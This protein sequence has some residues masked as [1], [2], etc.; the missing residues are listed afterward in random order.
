MRFSE[1]PA[2]PAG[3]AGL[4]KRGNPAQRPAVFLHGAGAN[5]LAWTTILEAFGDRSLFLLDL[6]GHGRS[7]LPE[8]WDLETTAQSVSQLVASVFPNDPILWVGHSWGGKLA[9]VI[10]AQTPEIAAGLVLLDPS[11]SSAVPINIEEFVDVI[12]SEELSSRASESE[13]ISA[14]Q[15]LPQWAPGGTEAAKAIARGVAANENGNWSLRP[16]RQA[17]VDLATAVLHQDATDLLSRAANNSELPTLLVLAEESLPWQEVTNKKL[18]ARA[19]HSV[20]PGNHW[21]H[22]ARHAAVCEEV[23]RWLHLLR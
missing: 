6:P 9:G 17:L 7:P 15:A 23:R 21:V 22:R 14:A 16:G 5:A 3:L 19:S 10:A 13:A 20:I 2:G 8:T 12:W 1:T 18:Y 4:H 11:P